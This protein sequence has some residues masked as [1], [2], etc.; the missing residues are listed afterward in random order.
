MKSRVVF[1]PEECERL[2]C[3]EKVTRCSQP[4]CSGPILHEPQINHPAQP[5][6]NA[7]CH[8]EVVPFVPCPTSHRCKRALGQNKD[9]RLLVW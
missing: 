4:C 2:H 6:Y 8:T 9:S 7:F 5:H 1:V 3:A